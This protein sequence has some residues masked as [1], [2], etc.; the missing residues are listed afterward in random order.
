MT[1]GVSQEAGGYLIS[2]LRGKASSFEKEYYDLIRSAFLKYTFQA[3]IGCMDGCFIAYHNGARIFGFQYCSIEEME[4]SLYGS[5]EEGEMVYRLCLGMLERVLGDVVDSF[6]VGKGVKLMFEAHE[7]GLNVFIEPLHPET[8]E[9]GLKLL[10]IEGNN[11]V[12]GVGM[13]E[14]DIGGNIRARRAKEV[15]KVLREAELA[16]QFSKEIEMMEQEEADEVHGEE[17]PP[18]PKYRN[19]RH[20]PIPSTSPPTSDL[21]TPPNARLPNW[22]VGYNSTLHDGTGEISTA[23]IK[24]RFDAT[25]AR[26]TRF[27]T[28]LLPSGVT[29]GIISDAHIRAD[30][31]LRLKMNPAPPLPVVDFDTN[32]TLS[33]HLP[34]PPA[35]IRPS[36]AASTAIV[37]RFPK[38]KGMK[39]TSRHHHGVLELRRLSR[40]GT[41]ELIR[42][43]EVDRK[44]GKVVQMAGGGMVV[45]KL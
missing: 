11:F 14:V 26:Q 34:P 12:D 9:V 31:D 27:S 30:E 37:R 6:G 7:E 38:L 15:S 32:L 21:P 39:Y 23:S 10:R 20:P 8:G 4:E 28:I 29:T 43:R 45:K 19:P 44:A 22:V 42:R 13:R 18:K 2:S 41:K 5:K 3:R 1:I 36:D 16:E 33:D 24:E 17:E 35:P 25:R 40:E